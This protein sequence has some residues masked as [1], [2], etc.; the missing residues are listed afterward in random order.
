MRPPL[1]KRAMVTQS[2][3]KVMASIIYDAGGMLLNDFLKS[4]LK[5]LVKFY[6]NVLL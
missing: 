2:E 3:S 1:P 4:R 6:S 5:I